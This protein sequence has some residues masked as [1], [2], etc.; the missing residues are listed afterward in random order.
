VRTALKAKNKLGFIDGTLTKPAEKEGDNSKLQAWEMANSMTASWIL[1]VIDPKLRTSVAY[2]DTAKT[3]WE[4]LKKRYAIASA[5]KIHQLKANI[6]NCKQGGLSI[7]EFYSKITD[8]WIEL[9]NYV[10]VPHCKCSGCKCGDANEIMQMYEEGK[11]DQFFMG[12][13]DDTY[14]QIRSQILTLNPLPS[15]NRIFNMVV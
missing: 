4:T 6:A 15:L 11:A 14:S 9:G 2:A 10:K 8:L 7:V 13:N 12:L 1:N 3:M 5:P